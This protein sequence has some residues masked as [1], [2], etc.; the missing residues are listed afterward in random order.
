MP[1]VKIPSRLMQVF[2]SAG[3]G[4]PLSREGLALARFKLDT[5]VRVAK[6]P[7]RLAIVG[8]GTMGQTI[9][10]SVRALDGWS[11]TALYDKFPTAAQRLHT[12]LAPKAAVYD[13]LAGLLAAP[14]AWDIMVIATTAD[15]H[16]AV[17]EAA[18]EAGVRKIFLEK[19]IATS[20]AEAD[21]LIEKAERSQAQ[22]AIDHTRRWIPASQGLRR[23]VQS[24][25]I[26][27]VCSIHFTFGRAGFAMIGTHLFDLTRWIFEAD[28]VKLSAELDEV[29]RESRRGSHFV[30]RSGRCQ[31][32]LSNGI[33]VT[34][35]LSDELALR[36]AF[37]V[38]FGERG[39]IE[40]DERLGR[41]RLVGYGG[42]VWEEGYPSLNA[43]ELGVATALYEMQIGKKPRCGLRDGRA[44]LEAAI[45]CQA[46]ARAGGQW[47][48]FP[49]NGDV[50]HEKFPFA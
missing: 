21:Q 2:R 22:V 49:L 42:R 39:R 15:S 17:A 50:Y 47:V 8:C 16:V 30:D 5:T 46:S 4:V 43:I 29:I 28:I 11:I 26:G 18:L 32:Q 45:G 31:A 36:Q 23:L 9:A 1:K 12:N 35:D 44:A 40:V 14:E 48:T 27:K 10:R 24:G 38:L 34:I 41:I 20:L 7:A 3:L 19:P 33:R 13:D 37:F 6:S 25:A